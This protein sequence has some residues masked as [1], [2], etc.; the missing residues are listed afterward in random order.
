M[1]VGCMQIYHFIYKGLKYPWILISEG[2]LELI[3]HGC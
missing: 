1:C 3:P 2:F